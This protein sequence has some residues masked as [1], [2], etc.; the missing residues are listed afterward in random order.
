[1]G[2]ADLIKPEHVIGGFAAADKK[3][4]LRELA[5]RAAAVLGRPNET[6]IGPIMAREDLG[7]TGIG[8]GFA[9]P[10][11]YVPG[12]TQFFGMFVRLQKPIDFAAVDHEPVDLV[13]LLL[14]PEGANKAH[15][16]ALAA[17]TRRLREPGLADRLRR[18]RDPVELYER[19]AGTA[20]PASRP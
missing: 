2:I 12:L 7:S 17:I 10:H 16:A 5:T 14:S 4:L 6:I 15:L 3:A 13:F 18:T 8:H 20:D 11:A 1:M 9:L 19:L